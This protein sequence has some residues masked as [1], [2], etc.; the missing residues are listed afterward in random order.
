MNTSTKILIG[1]IVF[2]LLMLSL[3]ECNRSKVANQLDTQRLVMDDSLT[4]LRNAFGSSVAYI[5]NITAA[6]TDFK[7]A[8]LK[9]TDSLGRELQ[10]KV[11]RRTVSAG[12]MTSVIDI[13]T[14]Y[15]TDTVFYAK[16]DTLP[17]YGF[18]YSDDW[19]TIVA[20][21]AADSFTFDLK[22]REKI[23]WQTENSRWRLF[24]PTTCQT[25][26]ITH[27]PDVTITGL[28]TFTVKC[29]CGKKSAIAFTAGNISGFAIGFLGGMVYQKFRP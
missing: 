29:D 26:L 20:K 28:R 22:I 9:E 23:E 4:V 27:N 25:K 14:V 18:T 10:K 21:A 19:K 16:G 12:V 5:T 13:D 8:K 3:S 11:N 24:K 15:E 1:I 7:V 17:T 2:L 6:Y